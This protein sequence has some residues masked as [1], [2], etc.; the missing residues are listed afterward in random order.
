MAQILC[1]IG[2][3]ISG[4]AAG[5][6]MGGGTVL[7][8]ILTLLVSIDQHS[9]QGINML[10]FLPAAIIAIIIHRREGRIDIKDC[11][12]IIIA[13]ILGAVGGA[14]LAMVVSSEWLKRIF[15]IFLL[16]LAIIQLISGEKNKNKGVD[17]QKRGR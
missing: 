10:S 7:I 8:P 5:M 13:G 12:P 11:L 2:G 9:A 6:G 15:G 17:S 14:M 16:G 4:V 3:L 1:I